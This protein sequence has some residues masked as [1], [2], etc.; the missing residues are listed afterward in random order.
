MGVLNV[1][2]DSFS[3]GGKFVDVHTA[4]R[5]ARAM[6]AAGADIIDIGGES[7]R[8][9]AA[10]VWEGE[11][12]ER[13]VPVIEAL[14]DE[15]IALSIDSRNAL[16]MEKAIE[17]G[18]HI[19]NDVSA[20]TH[21]PD[22]LALASRLNVPVVLMHAQGDPRTMQ[23]DPHYEHVVLD[24]YDYLA[25]RIA[26]CEAAGIQKANIIIDPGIGFGKRVVRDNMDLINGLMVF[27][28]LGCPVL[29][30]ASRK[31]FIGAITGVE[32]AE[33]R[34]AGSVAAAIMGAEQG[35][36]IIRVHDIRETAEAIKMVQASFDASA[37]DG[38]APAG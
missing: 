9:G 22:S 18:A 12:A 4:V 11:E 10:P 20:F 19:I 33:E 34:V 31:R 17:A 38:M 30:G 25:E 2:P 7:T 24:I 1:T 37:M 35:A 23:D 28:A 5:H 21:D 16:V 3:D 27:Q 32:S 6:A 14:A 26:A 29:L 13:V 36:N 15:G 8:P